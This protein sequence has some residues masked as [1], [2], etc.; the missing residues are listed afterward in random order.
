[1]TTVKKIYFWQYILMYSI[2]ES[3]PCCLFLSKSF[4]WAFLCV[5]VHTCMHVFLHMLYPDYKKLF[6]PP[7][8]SWE[9]DNRLGYNQVGP[10]KN[11]ITRIVCVC[12]WH[13]WAGGSDHVSSLPARPSHD[14]QGAELLERGCCHGLLHRRLIFRW[15]P[16]DQ[17]QVSSSDIR[18]MR[19]GSTNQRQTNAI[20]L[21]GRFYSDN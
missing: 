21:S 7:D 8:F 1:M 6:L 12:V 16:A 5:H 10:H 2:Y 15:T 14:C 17:V 4:W 3:L 19:W 9:N 11:R 18:P 13:R 20:T